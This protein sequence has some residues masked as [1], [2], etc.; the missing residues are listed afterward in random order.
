MTLPDTLLTTATDTT[1]VALPDTTAAALP[2]TTAA[3]QLLIMPLPDTTA[4]VTVTPMTELLAPYGEPLYPLVS[5]L[6]AV[7]SPYS[8]GT[9][10]DYTMRSDS[11]MT[12]VLLACF[13]MLMMSVTSSW[14][15]ITRQ[16]KSFFSSNSND[17][18]VGETTGE[19][20]FQFFLVLINCLL[21][22]IGIYLFIAKDTTTAY[23]LNDEV[24]FIGILLAM[25]IG[26]Y[27][28]KWVVYGSVNVVF[29]GGKKSLQWGRDFLAV[30]ALEGVLFFPL[31]LLLIY[32]NLTVLNALIYAV[33][34]LFL[35]KTLVFYKSWNI[36]F[37]E[38]GGLLQTFLYFCTLEIAPLLAF[39]GILR[40][41]VNALK[42]NF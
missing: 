30:T 17:D 38:N 23:V 32:F 35:N 42:L 13:V 4:T 8:A 15:F 7:N 37:K 33:F 39:V 19:L 40:I 10:A 31:V 24:P 41:A 14:S 21:I 20:Q 9:L 5:H 36:F 28:V 26:Y 12:V 2:D 18:S 3:A 11:L 25:T 27:V 6:P 16:V 22:A 29:F 34:V 1:A